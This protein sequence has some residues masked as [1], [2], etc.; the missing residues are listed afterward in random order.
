MN[1]PIRVVGVVIPAHNEE[2]LLPEALA[3]LRVAVGL[4]RQAGLTADVVVVA[5]ACTDSTAAIAREAGARLIEVQERC[6]GRAR[7][8]G[9]LGILQRHSQLPRDQI[10]LATTDADSRVPAQWLVVQLEHARAGA[11]LVLGTVSVD[12]WSAHPQHV[13][14]SWRRQYMARDG[15]PHVHGANVG[16]R[17]D[18]YL[19]VGGFASLD[20]DEDVALAA[21]LR[22]RNV[23]RTG[24]NA[25][26]TSA[27]QRS[28]IS[29]GFADHLAQ[30]A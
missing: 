12:D 24:A 1:R 8:T 16:A 27:R 28:R 25:V 10:W 14:Q 3:A 18:A 20:R 23:V 9:F 29:G 21:A 19:D 22:H 26:L 6:V 15:H 13:A 17:A 11:D 7:S 30:L 5:D 2:E 4:A